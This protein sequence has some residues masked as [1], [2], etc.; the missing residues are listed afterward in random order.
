MG[1]SVKLPGLISLARQRG[2][3]RKGHPKMNR[4]NPIFRTLI[5]WLAFAAA[6]LCNGAWASIQDD[7]LRDKPRPSDLVA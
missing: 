6:V 3:I 5:L 1:V 7:Q 4:S 2:R